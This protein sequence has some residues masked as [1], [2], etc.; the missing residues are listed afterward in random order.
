MHN[1]SG[2]HRSPSVCDS[3]TLGQISGLI[4]VV[5]SQYRDMVGQQLQGHNVE[6]R[7]QGLY[8]TRN[9]QGHMADTVSI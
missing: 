4:H 8:S 2:A 1:D 6:H 9:L 5:S 3:N 7:L